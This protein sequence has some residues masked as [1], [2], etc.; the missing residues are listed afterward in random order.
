MGKTVPF[1]GGAMMMIWDVYSQMPKAPMP[2]A[3]NTAAAIGGTPKR[4]NMMQDGWL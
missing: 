3:P 4:R 2:E 1:G